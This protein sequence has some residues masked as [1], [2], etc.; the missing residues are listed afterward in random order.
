VSPASASVPLG[1][2]VAD[3]DVGRDHFGLAVLPDDFDPVA[4]PFARGFRCTGVSR[5][6]LPSALANDVAERAG[7]RLV[8]TGHEAELVHARIERFRREEVREPWPRG[9]SKSLTARPPT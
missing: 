3:D 2:R 7:H 9:Y 1:P 8:T 4:G 5:R 6:T